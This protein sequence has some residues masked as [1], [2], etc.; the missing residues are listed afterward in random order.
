[1]VGGDVINSQFP[2]NKITKTAF[3]I[4]A[5][6]FLKEALL[7]TGFYGIDSAKNETLNDCIVMG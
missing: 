5:F 7:E 2:M 3:P 4:C 1:M 6:L